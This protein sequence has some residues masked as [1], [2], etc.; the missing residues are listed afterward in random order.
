MLAQRRENYAVV[1]AGHSKLVAAMVVD[2][3]GT[4]LFLPFG[5]VYFL[6]TTSISL[7]A[8]GA[9]L[10][11][12]AL[13]ALPAPLVAG[14][15][16]DRY[17]PRRMV[18]AGNMLSAAAFAGYLVVGSVWQLIAAALLASVGQA[19]F[20]TA[21][22][23]LVAAVAGPEQRASWFAL[24]TITRNI[25]Y[26]AGAILGAL[27]VA[28]GE[29]V[30]YYLLAATNAASFL[31]AGT[32]VIAAHV[33]HHRPTVPQTAPNQAKQPP[34][35]AGYRQIVIDPTLLIIGVINFVFVLSNS[36]LSVLLAVYLTSVL[37]TAAWLSG[38]LF[39]GETVLVITAQA[40]ITSRANRYPRTT[41]LTAA[42]I[43]YAF[44]FA[45]LWS[46]SAAP[47]W[48]IACGLIV[49]LAAFA[50]A[51]MLQGPIINTLATDTAPPQNTGRYL[52]VYQLSW[53]IGGGI[54]PA[55]LT[56]L[57]SANPSLPWITL[58]LGCVA[59]VAALHT[60]TL[61]ANQAATTTHA[62]GS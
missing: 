21:T 19:A 29:V 54:A 6:H 7:E 37:H 30:G 35:A 42:A 47:A 12:A 34:A 14:P 11:A 44:A 17:G 8:I 53:S 62:T 56:S 49:F 22:R 38:A 25:G 15:L 50:F 51:G 27:A 58:I 26:G 4:G 55:L 16:I 60:R 18:A 13:L 5:I 41:T 28:S 45:L 61:Q 39:A 33:P 52:A 57:L 43:C 40:S 1:F 10:S 32:L 9:S 36:V 3:V 48:L 46:L 31:V 59:A 23:S 2:G 24:Q 20:W